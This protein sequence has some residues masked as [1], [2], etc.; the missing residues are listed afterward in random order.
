MKI[1]V[2]LTQLS[3]GVLIGVALASG[4]YAVAATT[5]SKT[6]R[7]CVSKKSHVLTVQSRCPKG[8]TALSWSQ[9]GPRGVAGKTGAQGAAG[10]AGQAASVQV[11]TVTTS[12]TATQA[13]VT[14]VG[15]SSRA[16]LD[17]TLP[18][19]STAVASNGEQLRAWGQVLSNASGTNTMVPTLAYRSSNVM[20]VTSPAYGVYDIQISGC[21]DAGL[22]DPVI[23]ATPDEYKVNA[24]HDDSTGN[25]VALTT[26]WNVNPDN[27]YLV[28]EVETNDP[29]TN[30]R[31]DSDL[32]FSVIC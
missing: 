19:A 3:I 15:T 14:N 23:Q 20:D 31:V 9:Q 8:T 7:G 21:S 27:G 28:V 16:I 22:T 6:V 4:G 5:I 11:G 25:V 24:N 2:N 1:T 17:F 26:S 12:T 18:E 32:Q 10:T 13:A 29:A 30:D